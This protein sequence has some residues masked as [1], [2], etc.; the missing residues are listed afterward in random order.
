MMPS[1]AGWILRDD[2]GILSWFRSS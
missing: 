2:K 1:K